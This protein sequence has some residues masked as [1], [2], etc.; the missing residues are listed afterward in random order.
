MRLMPAFPGFLLQDVYPEERAFWFLP[1][2]G[3]PGP[4]VF[5][6]DVLLRAYLLGYGHRYDYF[7][8]GKYV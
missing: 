7:E 5:F 4:D 8:S 3:L 1:V 2:F 6:Q